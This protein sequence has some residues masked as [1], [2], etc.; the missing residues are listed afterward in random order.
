MR[1]C[2][3][4]ARWYH[5]PG[6]FFTELSFSSL[7]NY[8]WRRFQP[9]FAR[10]ACLTIRRLNM[11]GEMVGLV[12]VI[13]T[14]GIPIAGMYTYYSVRKLR[15]QE[16]LGDRA[17]RRRPHAT[18]AFPGGEFAPLRNSVGGGSTG[19]HTDLRTRRTHRA[20]RLGGWHVWRD[21]FHD[22]PGFLP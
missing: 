14:L 12:A 6:P 8:R 4:D 20:G 10:P 15:S 18:G 2:S 22:W 16:R 19:L 17:R 3:H 1:L 9:S 5:L 11:D 21:S 13:M 7:R